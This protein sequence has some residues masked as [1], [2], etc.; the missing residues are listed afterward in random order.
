MIGCIFRLLSDMVNGSGSENKHVMEK[1]TEE[2]RMQ[3]QVHTEMVT[4]AANSNQAVDTKRPAELIEVQC[5]KGKNEGLERSR[6]CFDEWLRRAL[7]KGAA[8]AHEFV[9]M[10]NEI[11]N[12]QLIRERKDENGKGH[13]I[14]DL[15]TVAGG[16]C[17]TM[18]NRMGGA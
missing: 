5:T 3:I 18:G 17:A 10:S 8:A 13:L 16:A 12:L 9:N 11:P 7:V 4:F 1:L 14:R 15:D 6:G 2:Q